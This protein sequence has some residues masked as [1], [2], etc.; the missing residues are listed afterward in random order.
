M[1]TSIFKYKCERECECECKCRQLFLVSSLKFQ[2]I[3]HFN[4]VHLIAMDSRFNFWGEKYYENYHLHFAVRLC[5][6]LNDLFMH[7][8]LPDNF[9]NVVINRIDWMHSKLLIQIFRTRSQINFITE[10]SPKFL[11][12][13]SSFPFPFGFNL[14]AC[15]AIEILATLTLCKCLSFGIW[16]Y[17][18]GI[19]IVICTAYTVVHDRFEFMTIN[20]DENRKIEPNLSMK[21]KHWKL[22]HSLT[23]NTICS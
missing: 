10:F 12:S 11:R 8:N 23:L 3:S 9:K 21:S 16:I 2:E 19:N 4:W 6:R 14:T 20:M 1:G 13:I 5:N 18:N 17:R 15:N 22:I 7:G